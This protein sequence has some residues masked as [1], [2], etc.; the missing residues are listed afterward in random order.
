MR[1]PRATAIRT[2]A[3]CGQQHH[4]SSQPTWFFTEGFVLMMVFVLVA[5]GIAHK[6]Q[7]IITIL[8]NQQHLHVDKV[9]QSAAAHI[10]QII[11]RTSS[12]SAQEDVGI[13]KNISKIAF[14]H[15]G[16]T[17]GSAI[18]CILHP[19]IHHSGFGNSQCNTSIN[20][21]NNITSSSSS[22]LSQKVVE[23]I[24]LQPAPFDRY[25]SF[26]ITT[27]NPIDR[28]ISWYYYLHPNYP[29]HKSA[30]HRRGCHDLDL[31]SCWTTIQSLSEHGLDQGDGEI[32]NN[33]ND[34]IEEKSNHNVT[35][36]KTWAWDS[37][38]GKRKCWH[39]YYNYNFTYGELVRVMEL[40]E[41]A[42]EQELG[43]YTN[44][45]RSKQKTIFVIRTEHLE[46]DW[47]TIN[48]ML[49]DK[50][51]TSGIHVPH[52]N[53]WSRTTE[54]NQSTPTLAAP[55]PTQNKTLSQRGRLNLCRAL[56]EEIQIY[57]KLL[58][59]A[60]NL[61]EK[62]EKRSLGELIISC[63]NESRKIRECK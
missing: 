40:E 27:R 59:L 61:D 5:L 7:E 26:L 52:K 1:V 2:A 38:I 20:N 18:T 29:P 13:Y 28:I 63:P 39:N 10:Q 43:I 14:V 33:G 48:I 31:F 46:Q 19:S 45:G 12:S 44:S 41:V 50:N 56:C 21:T 4:R 16:K 23:R 57:K 54:T 60:L 35:E 15:L 30:K 22:A 36:C 51:G 49:G 6:H 11:D 32:D 55:N 8:Q 62:S 17:A 47:Q 25:N 3:M 53:K 34:V 24:H 9:Q 42:G 37:I 58:G